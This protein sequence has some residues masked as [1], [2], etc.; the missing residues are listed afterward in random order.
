MVRYK[1]LYSR[2][3]DCDM[4]KLSGWLL[5]TYTAAFIPLIKATSLIKGISGES[6]KS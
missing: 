2:W 5:V 1:Y 4:N 6:K 3:A